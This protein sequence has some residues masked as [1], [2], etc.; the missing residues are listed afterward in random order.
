[1]H[2]CGRKCRETDG[3]VFGALVPWRAVLHPLAAR[4]NDGLPGANIEYLTVSCHSQAATEHERILIEL[5]RLRRLKPP[6]R[7]FHSCNA[8]RRR[9][10][11]HS[12]DEFFDYFRHV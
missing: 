10:R 12:T 6:G 11:I 3:D 2:R 9:F 5:G 7:T 8:Y 1:M 4:A